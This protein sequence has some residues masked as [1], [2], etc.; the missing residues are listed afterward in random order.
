MW[1]GGG[2]VWKKLLNFKRP[3]SGGQGVASGRWN[4]VCVWR[5]GGGL[6]EVI[7]F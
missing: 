6:E 3:V 2:E 5:G 7:E 4:C 1:G